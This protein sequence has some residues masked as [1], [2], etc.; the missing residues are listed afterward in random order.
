MATN[1]LAIKPPVQLSATARVRRSSMSMR[2]QVSGRDSP[3][4][5]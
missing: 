5:E 1:S 3:T 4:V 2:A